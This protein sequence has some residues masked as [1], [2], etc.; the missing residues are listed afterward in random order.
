MQHDIV[1]A[2][3]ACADA[4]E[5]HGL[6]VG[7]EATLPAPILLELVTRV[8]HPA[9]QISY[10]AG[11]LVPAGYDPAAANLAFVRSRIAEA[12]THG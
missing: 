1:E 5:G 6:V 3:A 12:L 7:L 2:L 4:A 11:D 10:D 9:V 8:G